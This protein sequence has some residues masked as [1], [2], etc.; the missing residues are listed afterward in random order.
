[1]LFQHT[2]QF[3]LRAHRHIANFVQKQ[4]TAIGVLKRAF[5]IG[6]RIG[7]STADVT[8]H[9]TFDQIFRDSSYVEGN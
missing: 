2:Q 4:R 1:M 5:A 7:V 9:F 6:Y 8:E 3:D